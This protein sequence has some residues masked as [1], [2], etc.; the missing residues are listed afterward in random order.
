VAAITL[1][2]REHHRK[3]QD[4]AK[5]VTVKSTDR[6]RMVDLRQKQEGEGREP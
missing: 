3:L 6:L 1:T 4:P 2:L 5:Q